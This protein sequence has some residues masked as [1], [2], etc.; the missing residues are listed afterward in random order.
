MTIYIRVDTVYFPLFLLFPIIP[1]IPTFLLLPIILVFLLCSII[2]I[3]LLFPIIPIIPIF[4]LF[5]YS[6]YFPINLKNKINFSERNWNLLFTS[7][8]TSKLTSSGHFIVF[9]LIWDSYADK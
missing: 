2:P 4:L 6:Y 7:K 9:F 3:F 8:S 5:L 1:I